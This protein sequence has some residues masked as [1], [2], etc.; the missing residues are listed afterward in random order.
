MGGLVDTSIN[1]IPDEIGKTVDN[2]VVLSRDD[3]LLS[4]HVKEDGMNYH[5]IMSKIWISSFLTVEYWRYQI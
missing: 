1:Y 2:K 5:P 4:C 3:E